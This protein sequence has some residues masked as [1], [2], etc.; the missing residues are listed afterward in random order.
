MKNSRTNHHQIKPYILLTIISSVVL[1]NI[2]NAGLKIYYIRHAEAGHNVKKAWQAKGIPESEWP[3]YVG[4]PD[5]FTP[6]GITQ[7]AIATEKLQK[8][9]F[10]FVATSPS[11]RTRNT[12]AP[13]LKV[14][15]KQAEIWPELREGYGMLKILDPN[16]PDVQEEILN[17]GEAI[18]VT[19][20]ESAYL[21]L[22]P[23]GENNHPNC[24]RSRS[25]NEKVA[26][27]K[28]VS[29]NAIKVIEERFGGSDQSILLVGHNSSGVSLM[30]LLLQKEPTIRRGLYATGMWMVEQQEDG[31]YELK[32]Y[33]NEPYEQK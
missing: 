18:V 32:M 15:N 11:W 7:V 13:Y 9:H 6:K 28:H 30:K 4:N 29:L 17:K 22:R 27:L 25:D 21:R 14:T 24:P 16:I 10:D 23:G 8:Y 5:A 26:Y 31:S 3:A 33:N 12:I 1:S 19:E 20:E 2:A